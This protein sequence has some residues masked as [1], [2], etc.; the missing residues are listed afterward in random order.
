MSRSVRF[1]HTKEY[2]WVCSI[3]WDFSNVELTGNHTRLILQDLNW[4]CLLRIHG[5]LLPVILSCQ[6]GHPP[7]FLHQLCHSDQRPR[8]VVASG[9]PSW[10][11]GVGFTYMRSQAWSTRLHNCLMAWGSPPNFF[12]PSL[13]ILL[14]IPQL[15][16]L[17]NSCSHMHGVRWFWSLPFTIS[18]CVTSLPI[19]HHLLTPKSSMTSRA[20]LI[21][22]AIK[23]NFHW[24]PTSN[25]TQNS[26]R[27]S[28][29]VKLNIT[30]E[31]SDVTWVSQTHLLPLLKVHD[32]IYI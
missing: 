6:V 11:W 20:E 23:Q 15:F 25:L 10:C 4:T 3:A 14:P 27:I 21:D 24:V 31:L 28:A 30:V 32:M 17:Y 12:F 29:V 1:V 9:L 26:G 8:H 18:C 16:L 5:R 22:A 13:L 2:W 7:S 19:L